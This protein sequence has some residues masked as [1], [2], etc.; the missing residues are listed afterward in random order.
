[1]YRV[2][3]NMKLSEHFTLSEFACKDGSKDIIVDYELIERLEMLRAEIGGNPV[4]IVSGY[5]TRT[6]NKQCGGI[7]TSKH[8]KGEAGDIKVKRKKPI[9]I[10]Y[11]AEKIGFKGIGVYPTFTH[12]DIGPERV[13]WKQ[14][15]AG[16]KTI[17]N[18]L[19]E[20]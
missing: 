12:V 4:I 19:N 14:N 16:V 20:V 7:S 15:K 3:E 8:L 5:R 10:A 9:E 17:I 1:M 13:Y 18:S 2:P 11:A 6:Y